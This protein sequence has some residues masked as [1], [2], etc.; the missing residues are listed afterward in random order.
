M[1]RDANGGE[2]RL[3]AA[4]HVAFL[5]NRGYTA[6][7]ASLPEPALARLG[8][9]SASLEVAADATLLPV[10]QRGDPDPLTA[11]EIALTVGPLRALGTR[12]VDVGPRNLA[13]VHPVHAGL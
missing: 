12:M 10:P 7:S 2:R 5:Q 11:E 13:A 9:V 8:T 1:L 3:P 6:V 4:A